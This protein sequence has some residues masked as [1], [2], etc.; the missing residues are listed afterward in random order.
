MQLV[1]WKLAAELARAL[2]A[3]QGH[4]VG[5]DLP[6]LDAFQVLQLVRRQASL[7]LVHQQ[8][9]DVQAIVLGVALLARKATLP[10]ALQHVRVPAH[11][12]VLGFDLCFL[13]FRSLLG[14]GVGL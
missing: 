5:L 10:L 6:A 8:A 7:H 9:L 2:I 3:A 1:A 12:D 4:A 13:S 11:V 14:V